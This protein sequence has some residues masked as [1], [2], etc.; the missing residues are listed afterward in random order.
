[1][2]ITNSG[3]LIINTDIII[4]IIVIV[5]LTL[6]STYLLGNLLVSHI[7]GGIRLSQGEEIHPI[8]YGQGTCPRNLR[9][10]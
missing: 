10:V 5:L 4:I 1:M 6:L 8:P 3:T 9:S 2:T 7:V